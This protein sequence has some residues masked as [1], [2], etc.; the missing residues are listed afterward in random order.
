MIHSADNSLPYAPRIGVH[1][2]YGSGPSEAL[3]SR[4]SPDPGDFEATIAL[5]NG[6]GNHLVAW[7]RQESRRI[8][9]LWR[10]T[11]SEVSSLF[12]GLAHPCNKVAH[13]PYPCNKTNNKRTAEWRCQMTIKSASAEIAVAASYS[14]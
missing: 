13:T 7:I 4:Y 5:L 11:D 14:S 10:L 2:S 3:L 9:H 6:L 12:S 1:L 8:R